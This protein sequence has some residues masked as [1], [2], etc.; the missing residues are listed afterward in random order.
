MMSTL[1]II[2]VLLACALAAQAPSRPR[3]ADRD[4][5][6]RTRLAVRIDSLL[7]QTQCR[8][9]GYPGCRPYAE[10]IAGGAADIHG[11]PPGGADTVRKLEWLLGR[12]VTEAKRPADSAPT[13]MLARIDEAECI[14]CVKCVRACPVDAIVGAAGQM[15][16]VLPDRCTGCELCVAPCPVDCISMVPVA[17]RRP[18]RWPYPAAAADG[19]P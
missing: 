15:H 3:P 14:G 6:R 8:Q 2:F 13:P 10:A 12:A 16:S 11:C 7:P 9:C 18:W 4:R 17:G 1:L 19:I 5:A